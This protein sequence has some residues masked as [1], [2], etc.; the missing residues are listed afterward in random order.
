[1]SRRRLTTSAV[2]IA[3]GDTSALSA[4]QIRN[5]STVRDAESMA[6][7]MKRVEEAERQ[8]GVPPNQATLL[9]PRHLHQLPPPLKKQNRK[10][11]RRNLRRSKDDPAETTNPRK[12]RGKSA[13]RA[14]R[15]VAAGPAVRHVA[16]QAGLRKQRERLATQ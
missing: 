10:R 4:Q 14:H 13:H 11:R 5:H 16:N 6:T 2:G 7:V 3:M 12:R 9:A 1:M 8:Q 15:R